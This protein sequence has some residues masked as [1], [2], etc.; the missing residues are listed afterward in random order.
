VRGWLVEGEDRRLLREAQ[1]DRRELSLT[2]T[3]GS[4]IAVL[5]MCCANTF[6]C[7]SGAFAIMC[8]WTSWAATVWNTS[9]C[10]EVFDARGKRQGDVGADDGNRSSDRFAREALN[11][12]GA[13]N[14]LARSCRHGAAEC[15]HEC[16]LA[17][18][19]WPHDG[20]TFAWANAQRNIAQDRG[21]AKVDLQVRPVTLGQVALLGTTMGSPAEFRQLLAAVDNQTWTPVI[22]SVRPL[23]DAAAAHEREEDGLHFGKLVLDCQ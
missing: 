20:D 2:G 22:D 18:T 17:G 8:V 7:R 15:T 16:G 10:H 9:E 19:V 13:E 5:Q 12:L 23:G 1:R 3:Q 11:R 21:A 14:D 6:N 4:Y